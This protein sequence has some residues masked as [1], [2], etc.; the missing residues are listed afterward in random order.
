VTALDNDLRALLLSTIQAQTPRDAISASL[1]SGSVLGACARACSARQRG[2]EEALLTQ[3]YELFRTGHLA[4]GLNL[5]N[6]DPP[7]FHITD[8]GRAALAHHNRDPSNPAGY[9]AHLSAIT[10]LNP[11][12]MSYLKEAV[13][14]YCA[15]L[16]K[17]AA[18]MTGGAAESL[19]LEL[20]DVCVARLRLTGQSP[21]KSLNDW[22]IRT[23][24]GAL[25]TLIAQPAA[26]LP[27]RL[28]ED[29]EAYW[30]ALVHQIRVVR[31]DAGHPSSVEP[32]TDETVHAQLLVFPEL[33]KITAALAQHFSKPQ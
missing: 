13:D 5:S 25:Q 21:S 30:P 19:I 4:W 2:L 9:F 14:C 10:L 23:V 24:A 1:Q 29:F 8:R 31:N 17:A 26:D 22:R 32:V 3:F 12:A 18:V 11:I 27:H 16:S 15:G 33:A 7:F 20:R 6:P 28:R